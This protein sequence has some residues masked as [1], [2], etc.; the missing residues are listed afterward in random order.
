MQT[1]LAKNSLHADCFHA[2][3]FVVWRWRARCPLRQQNPCPAHLQK[4]SKSQSD[5]T[6]LTC[7]SRH[8][9]FENSKK[10]GALPFFNAPSQFK[11]NLA[12]KKTFFLLSSGKKRF[13]PSKFSGFGA[14]LGATLRAFA[15]VAGQAAGRPPCKIRKDQMG[16]PFPQMAI[17]GVFFFRKENK[18]RLRRQNAVFFGKSN[19]FP[20]KNVNFKRR[21]EAFLRKSP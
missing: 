10:K 6:R 3:S 14:L 9:F 16:A 11:G 13:A 2:D 7:C 21:K 8:F 17:C 15:R 18:S 12:T 1:I 19:N 5:W 4:K 20:K